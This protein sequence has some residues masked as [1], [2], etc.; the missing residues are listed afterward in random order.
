LKRTG[1]LW[2]KGRLSGEKELICK[3][4]VMAGKGE[5]GVKGGLDEPR[6]SCS[7]ERRGF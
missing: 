5:G 2:Q 3:R 4:R 1:A 7:K 6:K